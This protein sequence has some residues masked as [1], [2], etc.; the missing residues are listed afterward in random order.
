M[1]QNGA[2]GGESRIDIVVAGAGYVGLATAVAIAQAQ[3]GLTVRI[4]DAAPEGAWQ[5]DQRASAIAAAA[6]RMLERLGCWSD[7]APHAQAITEMIVTDS[8]TADPVRPVLLTFS[9]EV[10]AGEPF[11]H[12]VPNKELNAALRAKA[13]ALGIK[14]TE[15]V[16]VTD[17]VTEPTFTRLTL[18]HGET[19]EASLLIA[20]DGV[21]SRLREK[22]G[23]RT[24]H[25]DY[26]QS[27]IVC[28]VAH[29]RPHHG[30]AVEHFLPAGPFA[31]LPL[32]GNRS[33]I[34]WTEKTT[35]A[36]RLVGADPLIFESELELRF[37]LEL[38][39][40][41]AEGKPRAFPLSLTLARD[42]VRPRFALVGDAAHGIHPIAG[43]GLNL[44]FKDAAAL[45]ETVVEAARLGQD[46]GALDIL[47]NYQRW[48]R[49]DTLRMGAT[50]DV[51]NRLFSNE[52]TLLRSIRD[53][54]LGLV[55]RMPP[56][57]SYFI[58]QAAS[59]ERNEPRL[60]QG[61]A[62]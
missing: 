42:F 27:G 51:L 41:R 2:L 28:T 34:V 38:G 59:Q 15:G 36:D 11:A 53:I 31:I 33:S 50:T 10:E 20:A 17:F 57:K 23:I 49:F 52:S 54:G 56:L 25:W 44:G 7:I 26:G 24:V 55:E 5:K 16:S 3:P 46:V 4:I 35:E 1:T 43:Q 13:E 45:A 47:E 62:I 14:L 58:D 32:T 39:E 8:K 22:A 9:G 37:G 40:I 12:M 21:K 29:E 60:L 18:S 6:C 30:R 61:E 48:R 19:V